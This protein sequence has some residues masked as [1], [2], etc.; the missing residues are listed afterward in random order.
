LI[1]RVAL[2]KP[3]V[4]Q[5]RERKGNREFNSRSTTGQISSAESV[6]PSVHVNIYNLARNALVGKHK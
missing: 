5:S 4:W 6:Y 2:L 3:R 1:R